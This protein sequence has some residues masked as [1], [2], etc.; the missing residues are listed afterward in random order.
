[1]FGFLSGSEFG[2][3][4]GT[5]VAVFSLLTIGFPLILQLIVSVTGV[6]GVGSA[7]ISLSIL[8]LAAG[9]YLRPVFVVVFV[10]SLIQ[11]CWR[12]MRSLGLPAWWG[13]IV[14]LLFAVDTS[15]F[16]FS[17]IHWGVTFPAG[18]PRVNLPLFAMTAVCIGIAMAYASSPSHGEQAGL[19]RFGN[20]GQVAGVLGAIV[21]VTALFFF[22]LY[23]WMVVT[24]WMSMTSVM[25]IL[26]VPIPLHEMGKTI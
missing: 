7:T 1:M 4:F 11:P 3:K 14:P 24:I 25:A 19:S 16:H 18:L 26:V 17:V 15:Y 10:A 5:R 6:R 21:G 20:A 2:W 9:L 13:L 8:A 22:V 12:R 23:I